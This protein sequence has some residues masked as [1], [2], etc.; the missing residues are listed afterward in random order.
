MDILNIGL[1]IGAI[2]NFSLL[3]YSIYKIKELEDGSVDFELDLGEVE[4]Q[5]NKIDKEISEI[6]NDF[7]KAIETTE[8][9]SKKE[10]DKSGKEIVKYLEKKIPPTNQELLDRIKKIEEESYRLRMNM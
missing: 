6:K 10:I 2:A 3:G 7:S 1:V 9:I 4:S 5:L 8:L